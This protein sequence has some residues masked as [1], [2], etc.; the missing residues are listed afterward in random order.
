MTTDGIAHHKLVLKNVRQDLQTYLQNAN[1]HLHRRKL[2]YSTR[3]TVVHM[4]EDG[5]GG[6]TPHTELPH[7]SV[8]YAPPSPPLLPLPPSP[9]PPPHQ[10][11]LQKLGKLSSGQ[12]AV[13]LS[14]AVGG[15]GH[16][17]H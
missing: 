4:Y 16:H 12:D 6:N 15:G 9:S 2:Q 10:N 13:V 5:G 8:K 7:M 14:G 17:H 11:R 1:M 3:I